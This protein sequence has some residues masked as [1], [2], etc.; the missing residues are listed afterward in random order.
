MTAF[1]AAATP[2]ARPAE[3][4][5]PRAGTWAQATLA[6]GAVLAV[7]VL[8]RIVFGPAHVGYDAWFALEWGRELAHGSIPMLDVRVGPTPHPLLNLVGALLAPFGHS[9]PAV[10]VALHFLAFGVLVVASG[11]LAL[12]LGGWLA[13][14]IAAVL[15][16]TRPLLVSELLFCSVDIVFLALVIG[17]GVLLV[18]PGARGRA[19]TVAAVLL[20]LAGLLR[21]EAWVL[22][23]ALAVWRTRH[24]SSPTRA[25]ALVLVAPV[26]W[27]ATDWIATGDP[28]WSLHHTQE[29]T[30]QLRRAQSLPTAVRRFPISLADVNGTAVAIVGTICAVL[31]ARRPGRARLLLLVLAA[32]AGV[33]LVLGVAGLPLLL[34]YTLLP[35]MA[36]LIAVGVG[37]GRLCG[38][39]AEH[40]PRSLAIGIGAV[41]VAGL[42][43]QLVPDA[44]ST[45]DVIG[46]GRYQLLMERDLDALLAAPQLR[47][48]VARCGAPVVPHYRPV[49][50]IAY[51]LGMTP[52]RPV[53][54]S[55]AANPVL[56]DPLPGRAAAAYR[57]SP[58]DRDAFAADAVFGTTL[59]ATNAHW[60]LRERCTVR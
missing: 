53:A 14:V 31:L 57:L 50:Q 32:G 37:V 40:A 2:G 20:L 51:R 43:A 19:G 41:A 21:P 42:G 58:I 46:A 23:A 47:T 28:L 27:A 56:L 60:A 18:G 45:A 34:R 15:V 16:G 59:V 25:W 17:A 12:R 38:W 10:L 26:L 29:L 9:A 13:A 39:L 35:A 49:P 33:W 22:A 48:L 55:G 3:R 54:G 11:W 36:G 4:T 44:R 24:G 52:D 1:A 30:D 8:A 5:A 7:A 6:I